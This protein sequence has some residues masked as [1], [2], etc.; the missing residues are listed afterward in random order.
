MYIKKSL[1]NKKINET[2]WTTISD[3]FVELKQPKFK[4]PKRLNTKIKNEFFIFKN[5]FKEK[6]KN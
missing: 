5:K 4:Q 1:I 6:M 3:H 2:S